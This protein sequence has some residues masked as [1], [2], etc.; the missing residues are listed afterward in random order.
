VTSRSSQLLAALSSS[1]SKWSSCI[2]YCIAVVLST[3]YRPASGQTCGEVGE[4]ERHI[5]TLNINLKDAIDWLPQRSKLGQRAEEKPLLLDAIDVWKD[6]DKTRVNRLLRIEPPEVA[7][8]VRNQHK[9]PVAGIARDIPVL[10][11]GLADT[12]N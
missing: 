7:G 6:D 1:H 2:I 4:G 9:I 12:G 8:V 11:T 5:I 10:P 3:V